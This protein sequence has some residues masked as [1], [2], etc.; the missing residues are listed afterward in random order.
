MLCKP[1]HAVAIE[2]HEHAS[3]R[4]KAMAAGDDS[5]PC[6]IRS[7]NTPGMQR[8]APVPDLRRGLVLYRPSDE[9]AIQMFI[10]E[11]AVV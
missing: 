8:N 2:L 6:A 7:G 1:V 5:R 9:I 3:T 11:T 10:Q 4:T